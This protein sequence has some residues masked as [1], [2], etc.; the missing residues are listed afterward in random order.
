[1]RKGKLLWSLISSLR[2]QQ[3]QRIEEGRRDVDRTLPVPSWKA[4]VCTLWWGWLINVSHAIIK[5]CN[6]NDRIVS[7]YAF[8]TNITVRL[9]IG[10]ELLLFCHM[11][12]TQLLWLLLAL[13][14]SL[15]PH[16]T[17]FTLLSLIVDIPNCS[18]LAK[19]LIGLCGGQHSFH[20]RAISSEERA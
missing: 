16:F 18:F 12:H 3:K 1:M 9:N 14:S 19:M 17:H 11:C 4:S 15:W 8:C 10:H 2:K 13:S 20:N 6:K 7:N 5:W